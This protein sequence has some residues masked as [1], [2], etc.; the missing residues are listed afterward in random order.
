MT[1][2]ELRHLSR[3]ELLQMLLTQVEKNERLQAELDELKDQLEHR[4]AVFEQSGTLAEASLQLS[5]VFEAADRAAR[6]YLAGIQSMN[7]RQEEI[8]AEAR[9]NADRIIAKADAYKA[10]RIREADEYWEQVRAKV[11]NLMEAQQSLA[12]PNPSG[13][14]NR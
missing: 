4:T 3:T 2:K 1:D 8:E 6:D 10:A 11:N 7:A 5:G 13:E 14:R 9:K 12:A